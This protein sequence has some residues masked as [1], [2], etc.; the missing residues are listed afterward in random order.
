MGMLVH[1]LG[2]FTGFLGPLIIW[3]VKKDAS[4]FVDDQGKDT[5][6]FKLSMLIWYLSIGV[7]TCLTLGFAGLLIFPAIVVELVFGILAAVATNRGEAY[8]YPLTLRMIR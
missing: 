2:I 3:L 7:L 1:I 6:N 8:R 5:L 4:P